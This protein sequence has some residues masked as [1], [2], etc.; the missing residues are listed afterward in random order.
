MQIKSL[1]LGGLLLSLVTCQEDE[2]LK[3]SMPK[4]Y[5]GKMVDSEGKTYYGFPPGVQ[6][7]LLPYNGGLTCH[8]NETISSPSTFFARAGC[9]IKWLQLSDKEQP[10]YMVNDVRIIHVMPPGDS[11]SDRNSACPKGFGRFG[12]V[13]S[14][15]G[16]GQVCCARRILDDGIIVPDVASIK[17]AEQ[18]R[19]AMDAAQG[20]NGKSKAEKPTG[21]PKKADWDSWK[22]Q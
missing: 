18:H 10:C 17:E 13:K 5:R 15:P 7:V 11:E 2:D 9:D 6:Q 21:R 12:D 14:A 1:M 3:K 22:F 20:H 19:K 8:V 16:E 4:E